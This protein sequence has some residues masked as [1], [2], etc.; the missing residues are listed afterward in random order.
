MLLD[1]RARL[2]LLEHDPAGALEDAC[3]SG[4][5]V[6]AAGVSS[7]QIPWRS[8]AALAAMALGQRERAQQLAAEELKRAQRTH[9]ARTCGM[10]LRLV[11]LIEGG[12]AGIA[13]LRDAVSMLE[14][15]PSR[16]EYARALIDLGSLL[17]RA[18]Q[19]TA[20]RQPLRDGLDLAVRS[21]ALALAET[22]REELRAS[23]ARPRRAALRGVESLTASEYRVAV[24]AADGLSNRDIAQELF[25]TTKAVEYHLRHVFQK[26]EI[27]SR[28]ELP[29]A[30]LTGNLVVA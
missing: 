21:G 27:S 19:R 3:E 22:A 20:S 26:L 25:V 13:R 29:P 4:R 18:G 28:T 9:V 24:L 30:L 6:A 14:H 15:S 11:G 5:R 10:A 16:L 8:T 1:A 12:D 2:R 17:R 7:R 23:G